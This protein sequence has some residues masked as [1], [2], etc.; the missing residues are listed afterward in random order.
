MFQSTTKRFE[1]EF[2]LRLS[3]LGSSAF[4]VGAYILFSWNN[5][6]QASTSLTSEYYW[7][8]HA[9][10]FLQQ[11][12]MDEMILGFPILSLKIQVGNITQFARAII[13][14]ILF[15]QLSSRHSLH[16]KDHSMVIVFIK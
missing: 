16:R 11:L 13:Q 14:M 1:F 4:K 3:S 9:F 2:E 5:I 12:L 8:F 15:S 6:E 7:Q 10:L